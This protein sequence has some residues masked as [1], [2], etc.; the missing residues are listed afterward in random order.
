MQGQMQSGESGPFPAQEEQEFPVGWRRGLCSVFPRIFIYLY[1]PWD[2]GEW[3]D[4]I[5]EILTWNALQNCAACECLYIHNLHQTS[6]AWA[7]TVLLTLP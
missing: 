5:R 2:H 3:G 7:P 6:E 1:L 4:Q